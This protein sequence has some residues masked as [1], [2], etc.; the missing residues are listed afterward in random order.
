MTEDSSSDDEGL[1]DGTTP[2]EALLAAL[3]AGDPNETAKRL[4][5]V[6][7]LEQQELTLLAALFDGGD[8]DDPAFKRFFPSRLH[9]KAWRPGAPRRPGLAFTRSLALQSYMA[10]AKE[11]GVAPKAAKEDAAKKFGLSRSTVATS[12]A[13]QKRPRSRKG[14]SAPP[15][16][17]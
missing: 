15:E 5:Q 9:F 7:R 17:N 12:V 4:R 11:K 14:P 13:K 6:D 1:E 16:S 8:P 2:L 10:D 3:A